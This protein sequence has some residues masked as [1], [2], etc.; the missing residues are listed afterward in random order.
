MI[1]QP[2]LHQHATVGVD[3][4]D[5]AQGSA[6]VFAADACLMPRRLR[7]HAAAKPEDPAA[8]QPHKLLYA[9]PRRLRVCLGQPTTDQQR[10]FCRDLAV[11]YAAPKFCDYREALRCHSVNSICSGRVGHKTRTS[12]K[13]RTCEGHGQLT[14]HPPK[15]F[16]S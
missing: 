9:I 6:A 11:D 1:R 8:T 7:S 2:T 12:R 4:H 5:H 13:Q 16:H 3:D 15:R 14:Q 10:D